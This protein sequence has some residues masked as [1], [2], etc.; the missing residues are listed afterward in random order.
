MRVPNHCS[1]YIVLFYVCCR[2]DVLIKTETKTVG[3]QPE[4]MFRFI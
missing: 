2:T 3:K 4:D 1:I